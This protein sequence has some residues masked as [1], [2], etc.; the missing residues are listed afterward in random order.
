MQ[1]IIKKYKT[2]FCA[3]RDLGGFMRVISGVSAYL[4]QAGYALEQISRAIYL[5]RTE[6]DNPNRSLYENNK[7]VYSL[8][9]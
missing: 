8:V 1:T 9:R 2:Y 7:A 6:V 5:L 3:L 4:T